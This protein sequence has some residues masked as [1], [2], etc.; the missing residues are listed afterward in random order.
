MLPKLKVVAPT[1]GIR[2]AAAVVRAASAD[3]AAT[4]AQLDS[5]PDGLADDEADRRRERYGRNVVVPDARHGPLRLLGR[6]LANPLV[7]LLGVLAGVSYATGDTRAGTVMVLMVVL[8]VGL[9]F[10]QESRAD[11]AAARL[12]ALIRVTCTV[13]RNG[14]TREVPLE[15]LV[16][17]D[18]VELAA[19]DMV[20]ADVRLLTCKDLHVV[21]S[22]LTGEAF[23]AEKADA[24]E[25]AG[26]PPLEF[27]NVCFLGTSVESGTARAVVA[28]TGRET[29][30]GGMAGA[31]TD[32]PPPTAFDRGVARFTWLMIRLILVM[33]PLVFLI[34]G[35]TKGNWGEAFF[36]AVAVAVGLT[37][38]ML[39]MIVAVCLSRGAVAMSRRRSS[40]SGSTPSRTSA[41]WTFSAPTRPAP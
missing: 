2:V 29:Y 27:R 6:A 16:P 36:F 40:S 8:G 17:G 23:P 41:R 19:G 14:E 28:A 30:L 13:R 15:D 1:P 26:R 39:P 5:T 32:E 7:V 34:N 25:P 35:L 22:S 33:V 38:E 20:P 37:P 10:V 18:V 31:I 4:L 11:A 12:K 21:Q 24:P 3:A 9:R